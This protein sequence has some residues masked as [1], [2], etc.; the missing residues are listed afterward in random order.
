MLTA[1]D[2]FGRSQDGNNNAYSQDN[3]IT[4]LDWPKANQ[5][6]I[7]YVSMINGLRAKHESFFEDKFVTSGDA[8]WFDAQGGQ[9]DWQR[10][11]NRFLG[12]L[13][14]RDNDALAIMFNAGDQEAAPILPATTTQKWNRIFASAEGANCPPHAVAIFALV[15]ASIN[16]SF[17]GIVKVQTS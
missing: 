7:E 16:L 5:R 15:A 11:E 3:A 14:K 1:G 9:L 10:K 13:L 2:E 8:T 4:W 12:L 17:D 6:L